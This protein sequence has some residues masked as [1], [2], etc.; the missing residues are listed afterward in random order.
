MRQY[1][2]KSL[3]IIVYVAKC[4]KTGCCFTIGF[5]NQY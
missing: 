3:Q 4:G 1:E 2:V 5:N